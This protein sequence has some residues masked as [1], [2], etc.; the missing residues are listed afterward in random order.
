MEVKFKYNVGDTVKLMKCPTHQ[1]MALCNYVTESDFTPKEYVISKCKCVIKSDNEPKVF[2]NLHAYCDEYIQYHNW[3]P[4]D[5]LEGDINEHIENVEFIS[6]DN[7]VLHAGDTVLVDVF[8]GDY[9]HPS[10]YPAMTFGYVT[11]ILSL[12]YEIT[13][14]TSV[15]RKARVEKDK[16]TMDEF[17]PYI[18]KH[19][20]EKFAIEYV[21]SC[22]L[23]RFN[24]I[25]EAETKYRSHHKKLLESLKLWDKVVEIY[26]NWNKIRTEKT[27]KNTTEK[28]TT[29]KKN[30]AKTNMKKLFESLSEDEIKE[31]KKLI[32]NE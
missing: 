12:E 28:K 21:K 2:Y 3:I 14:K 30:I 8:S 31:L 29:T 19:P 6:H 9:E 32:N 7:E 1:N 17:T 23:N 27:P 10:L 25:K 26:N 15:I 11:E 5:E 16:I 22:K 13:E 18:V 4:E 20:D 24:P